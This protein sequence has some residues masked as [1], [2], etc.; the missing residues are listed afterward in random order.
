MSEEGNTRFREIVDLNVEMFPEAKG[1]EKE[2]LIL[3][4]R[5]QLDTEGFRYVK[6]GIPI[7]SNDPLLASLLNKKIANRWGTVVFKMKRK[8]EEK[9]ERQ[10]AEQESQKRFKAI[11][12]SRRDAIIREVDQRGIVAAMN[13]PTTVTYQA[14]YDSAHQELIDTH[15]DHQRP[16]VPTPRRAGIGLYPHQASRPTAEAAAPDLVV[17]NSA[18]GDPNTLLLNATGQQPVSTTARVPTSVSLQDPAGTLFD[19]SVQRFHS[20]ASDANKIPTIEHDDRANTPHR[21]GGSSTIEAQSVTPSPALEKC[22]LLETC[23]KAT[24]AKRTIAGL[25]DATNK[26]SLNMRSTGSSGSLN[27]FGMAASPFASPRT[28]NNLWT[29]LAEQHVQHD[30]HRPDHVSRIALV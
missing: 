18:I 20:I 3:Q 22:F 30:D 4:I 12:D 15:H 8:A 25:S 5:E 28:E 2:E 1:S 14:I 10:E 7:A 26:T 21:V 13:D 17:S 29:E 6:D 23:P 11:F 27:A 19:R 16:V 9:A 24:A